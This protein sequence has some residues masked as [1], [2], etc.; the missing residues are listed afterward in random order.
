MQ[1]YQKQLQQWM[2][3]EPEIIIYMDIGT[4]Q[5]TISRLKRY[6][7]ACDDDYISTLIEILV[8]EIDAYY[9]PPDPNAP[10]PDF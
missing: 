6:P 7:D 1:R 3:S 9:N 4:A 2:K 8:E 5:E 10:E